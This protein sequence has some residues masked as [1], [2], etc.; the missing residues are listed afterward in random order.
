M[1]LTPT[2]V[3]LHRAR[4]V[5]WQ[6]SAVVAIAATFDG[7]AV[8]VAREDGSIE[9][10]DSIGEWTCDLFIPGEE[11]A[12]FTSL[13]WCRCSEAEPTLPTYLQCRLFSA[14]L[15][16]FITEWDLQ[17]LSVRKSVESLGGPVWRLVGEPQP[18]S[19]RQL[20]A[21]AC[22][23]GCLRL[24]NIEETNSGGRPGAHYKRSFGN[25]G[26]RILSVAW[27]CSGE[28]LVS[29]S[30]D[31][32][33][34]LWDPES[35]QQLQRITV[36]AGG[37]RKPGAEL[38]VWSVLALADGTVVSGD[39]TGRVQFWDSAMGT[40][41][42]G[43]HEH[44]GDILSLAA[45]PKGNDVFASGV[46]HQVVLFQ[47]VGQDAGEKEG[48]AVVD[49]G[50]H[51]VMAG[52]KR[53]HSHDVRALTMAAAPGAPA[54]ACVLLSGGNDAQLNAYIATNF[55][56]EHPVCVSKWPQRPAVQLVQPNM[57][58]AQQPLWVDLWK[59]GKASEG[60]GEGSD[61]E[62]AEPP[63][64]AARVRVSDGKH[65]T[66]SALAPSGA[67]LAL[68]GVGG[69][70]VYELDLE[71]SLEG[72]AEAAV[73]RLAIK[74]GMPGA[75]ALAFTAD[76][77]CLLLATFDGCI[78]IYHMAKQQKIKVLSEHLEAVPGV[79]EAGEPSDGAQ[80]AHVAMMAV[81]RDGMWLAAAR[82]AMG[83]A[84]GPG[85]VHLYH[86]E[87]QRLHAT[88]ALPLEGSTQERLP[89][90]TSLAF[91]PASDILVVT[92]ATNQLHVFDVEAK[93]LTP[94]SREH[95]RKLPARMLHMPGHLS[96][97]TFHPAPPEGK[98]PLIVHTPAAL[99]HIDVLRAPLDED[100]PPAP[101]P[102]KR[103][104]KPPPKGQAFGGGG[105]G[106][107]FRVIPLDDPCLGLMFADSKNV[108]LV[109]CPWS[110]CLRGFPAPLY[111]HVY[112][113]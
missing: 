71:S 70:R 39:A 103:Q 82:S 54:G 84:G 78:H 109:E 94:W 107:N 100:A 9:L 83:R 7:E 105:P 3:A 89:R 36:G 88:L 69:T 23:D 27:N 21:A 19:D 46:D 86:L 10:Y 92:T 112:G 37:V 20:L 12:A 28:W 35:G 44:K 57:L 48:A 93:E 41:L 110:R 65:L 73:R 24:F 25:V 26:A 64:H 61:V 13:V 59:L 77:T 67:Y 80:R 95:G 99:C 33:I 62:M 66:C 98:C 51:W 43:F 30:S 85:Q 40:L 79:A 76:S 58:L 17:N 52:K 6:P 38:C 11:G 74:G 113:T 42:N 29:G 45:T 53:P 14:D 47:R 72:G 101:P 102:R 31:G 87:A 60:T 111:K 108:V 55:L 4:F 34:H 32:C 91:S 63:S 90:V 81:S 104:R 15:N 106:E 97:I 96:G 18:S 2:H 49:G 56:H 8:A 1:T 75:R 68:A 5:D 22:D 50:A 16:G